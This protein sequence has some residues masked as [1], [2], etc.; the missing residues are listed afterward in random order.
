MQK[1][2]DA[3]EIGEVYCLGRCYENN[4]FHCNGDSYSG[5]AANQISE[6]K[7]GHV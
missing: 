7:N 5:D 6:I 3:S 1:M 2:F 4:A